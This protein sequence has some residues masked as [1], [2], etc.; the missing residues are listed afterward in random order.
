L[1]GGGERGGAVFKVNRPREE[2]RRSQEG[3]VPAYSNFELGTS[4]HPP[5]IV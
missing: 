2:A 4:S 1:M 5:R 3:P